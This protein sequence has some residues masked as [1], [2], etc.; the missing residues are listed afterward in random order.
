MAIR[1]EFEKTYEEIE[2]AGRV[3]KLHLDD[4]SLRDHQNTLLEF[5]DDTKKMQMIDAETA[6][7]EEQ[8]KALD[9][10]KEMLR[11]FFDQLFGKGS[12][13]QL[14]LDSGKSLI[15]MVNLGEAVGDVINDKVEEMRDKQKSKYIKNKNRANLK[16]KQAIDEANKQRRQKQNRNKNKRR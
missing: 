2:V 9:E 4:E 10:A 14:Y 13:D 7:P 6:T 3:Y 12:F 1:F 8:D 15:N 11:K 16:K 5:Y